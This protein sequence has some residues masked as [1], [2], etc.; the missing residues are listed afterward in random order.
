[1]FDFTTLLKQV[2]LGCLGFIGLEIVPNGI[3][4]LQDG[5]GRTTG[6]AFVEFASPQ[7][8]ALALEKHKERI[9]HRW[10]GLKAGSYKAWAPCASDWA[11]PYI[12]VGSLNVV[13]SGVG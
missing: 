1:M 7:I 3:T 4:L 5:Q 11:R 10:D 12:V 9:G 8:A 2:S 13:L 6:D